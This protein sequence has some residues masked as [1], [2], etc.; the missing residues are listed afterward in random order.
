MLAPLI[1]ALNN[2]VGNYAELFAATVVSAMAL[3]K[4][5]LW[6]RLLYDTS[7]GD[8]PHGV[9]GKLER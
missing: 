2:D 4:M 5:T 8:R 6:E 9:L 7:F 1:P 3:R